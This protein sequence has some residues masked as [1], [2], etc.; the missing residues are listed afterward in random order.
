MALRGFVFCL[1]C[2]KLGGSVGAWIGQRLD[3]AV[4][5]KEMPF[6]SGCSGIRLAGE[7]FLRA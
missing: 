1:A 6:V 5:G 7:N 2:F 4:A 3:D